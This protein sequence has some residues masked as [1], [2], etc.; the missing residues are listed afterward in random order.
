[1][2]KKMPAEITSRHVDLPISALSEYN[3]ILLSTNVYQETK[4]VVVIPKGWKR[5]LYGNTQAGDMC[6]FYSWASF[7]ELESN[8]TGVRMDRHNDMKNHWGSLVIRKYHRFPGK[9]GL[10][11]HAALRGEHDEEG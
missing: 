8:R 5:V 9:F 4:K 3:T 11:I 7:V 2:I 1:M 10:L 6:Y